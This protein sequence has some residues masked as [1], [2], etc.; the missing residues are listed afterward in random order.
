MNRKAAFSL[1]ARWVLDSGVQVGGRGP[2]GGAFNAWHDLESRRF[3]YVYPEIT[4]YGITTLLYL[5][6]L[7]RPGNILARSCKA[8]D[9][10]L[11][12]AIHSSGGIRPR[13]F[14]ERQERS[15]LFSFDRRLVV[16][17]DSGM[18]L[19][20][21]TNLY[22]ASGRGEYLK[23]ARR[24]ADFLIGSA[25]KKDGFFH[26]CLDPGRS[27]WT[28]RPDKWSAQSG[29]YHAKLAI[30]LLHLARLSGQA[31]YRRSA[32][33]LCRRSLKA[34]RPSGRFVCYR[35]DGSTHMH[36]HLYA[37]E[38]MLWAGLELDEPRF[39]ES[40]TQAVA[41]ALS[42]Q[43]PDGGLP[44]RAGE[45]RQETNSNERSDTLA[46]ALRLGALCLGLGTLSSSARP[47]LD[48]L[49]RR[50][51]AF[52]KKRGP[53]A[54]GFLYGQEMNGESRSHVNFWCTAFALQ[55][56]AMRCEQAAGRTPDARHFI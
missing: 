35:A 54:G 30:G 14:Y 12:H 21:L 39:V 17:F 20:G 53:Q 44:C 13:D 41:W 5:D 26:A 29:P 42:V 48:R 25:Q 43:R 11:R 27:G 8:G 49:E 3:Q 45:I 23:A 28:E 18:V 16:T 24:V 34:Q 9:W 15:P 50:L 52:Q 37:A 10:I 47:R 31:L 56:L 7:G 40:A 2:L 33:R 36:P 4:G 22:E 32:E 55:A 1:A 19:F 6:S 46:Q 38:G 51:L